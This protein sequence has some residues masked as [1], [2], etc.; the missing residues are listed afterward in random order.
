[1]ATPCTDRGTIWLCF[2]VLTHFPCGTPTCETH[3]FSY[4]FM[5]RC[6]FVSRHVSWYGRLESNCHSRTGIFPVPVTSGALR[7]SALCLCMFVR[8][9]LA[10]LCASVVNCSRLLE[11][12]KPALTFSGSNFHIGLCAGRLIAFHALLESIGPLGVPRRCP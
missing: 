11:M 3:D 1:M 10:L 8:Q 5:L 9:L 12:L 7:G 2:Q 4:I 6:A